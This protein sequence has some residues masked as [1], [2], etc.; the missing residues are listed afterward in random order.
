MT[1][2]P[3][4][5]HHEQGMLKA[6]VDVA[7]DRSHAAILNAIERHQAEAQAAAANNAMVNAPLVSAL[8]QALRQ[9][10][11][12]TAGDTKLSRWIKAAA[13][14]FIHSDDDEHDF[15]S[16]IG[17]ED[18]AEVVNACLR[19]CGLDDLCVRVEDYDGN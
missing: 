9:G 17:F 19:F 14:Y 8:A 10:L 7:G 13:L 15:D 1:D 2:L 12:R 4:L 16:P 5:N 3:E 6:L 11:E 18:D